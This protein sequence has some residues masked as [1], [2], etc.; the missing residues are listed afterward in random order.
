MEGKGEREREIEMRNW[1]YKVYS[2][3][4]VGCAKVLCAVC[5]VETCRS[6]ESD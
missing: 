2:H 1:S 6:W 5:L 4:R 3:V